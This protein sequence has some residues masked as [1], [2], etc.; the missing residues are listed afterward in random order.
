VTVTENDIARAIIQLLEVERSVVEGA[1]AAGLAALYS[2]HLPKKCKKTV[3]VVSGSNIDM[4]MLSR[5]IER[6]MAERNRLLRLKVS[7]PDR[8]GSLH[9]MT[10]MIAKEHGNIISVVHDRSFSQLPGNVDISFLIE[11]RNKEHRERIL[12]HLDAAGFDAVIA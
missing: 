5:L 8:P 9:S 11:V 12:T 3:V 2:D 6:D 4:N 7:L 10:D 1:G